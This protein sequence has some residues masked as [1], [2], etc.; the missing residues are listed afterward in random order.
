MAAESFENLRVYWAEEDLSD[1]VTDIISGWDSFTKETIGKQLVR[2][3]DSIGATIAESSGRGSYLDNKRF[4]KI[5]RASLYETKHFLR[6]VHKRKLL[7]P[8]LNAYLKSIGQT[9]ATNDQ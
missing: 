4:I 7:A 6:R 8:M 5:A 1:L 2:S 3:A 9:K